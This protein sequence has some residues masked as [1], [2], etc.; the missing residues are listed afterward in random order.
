LKDIQKHFGSNQHIV[1]AYKITMEGEQYFRGNVGN[2]LRICE[3]KKLK[4]EFVLLIDNR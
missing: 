3:Q 2:I 1:L 4:G